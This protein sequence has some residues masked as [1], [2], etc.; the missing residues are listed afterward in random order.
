MAKHLLKIFLVLCACAPMVLLV[1]DMGRRYP[2][3]TP[4][5]EIALIDA[6][7][8]VVALVLPVFLLPRLGVDWR[9]DPDEY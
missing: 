5:A 3:D 4:L 7:L 2:L 9:R 8:L 6:A 1:L